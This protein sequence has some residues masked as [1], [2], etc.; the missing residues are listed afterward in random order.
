MIQESS[1]NEEKKVKKMHFR[2]SYIKNKQVFHK[3]FDSLN[4]MK[5]FNEANQIKNHNLYKIYSFDEIVKNGKIVCI[6]GD[7]DL[8][9]SKISNFLNKKEKNL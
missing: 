4:E 6:E 1:K 9:D 7:E 2:A 5:R 8:Y 3:N